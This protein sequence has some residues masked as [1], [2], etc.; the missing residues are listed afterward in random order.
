MQGMQ[1]AG[2]PASLWKL[3]HTHK[4]TKAR[5]TPRHVRVPRPTPCLPRA[6]RQ[7]LPRD[8]SPNSPTSSGHAG[9]SFHGTRL[10]S[11]AQWTLR[12]KAWEPTEFFGWRTR[13]EK[14]SKPLDAQWTWGKKGIR[15]W[16]VEFKGEPFPQKRGNKGSTG[17][18]GY[19]VYP[20]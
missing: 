8:L 1:S 7:N 20:K 13:N 10:R 19:T 6:K 9:M 15:F 2:M 17:Q 14:S 16:L 4:H 12:K 11:S 5:P 3:T 18:L